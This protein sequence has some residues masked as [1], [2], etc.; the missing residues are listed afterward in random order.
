[1]EPELKLLWNI[2]ERDA[3]ISARKRASSGGVHVSD[4]F[5]EQEIKVL[6]NDSLDTIE[7]VSDGEHLNLQADPE[8]LEERRQQEQLM[9]MTMFFNYNED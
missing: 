3:Y 2:T 1:M 5:E 6:H 8:Q 9:Q 4:L 7:L